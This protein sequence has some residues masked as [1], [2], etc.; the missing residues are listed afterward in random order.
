MWVTL[1]SVLLGLLAFFFYRN[2][3][4]KKAFRKKFEEI[5]GSGGSGQ[6]AVEKKTYSDELGIKPEVAT[7][8]IRQL[9][10]FERDKKFLEKDLTLV[11]LAAIFQTNSKYVSIIIH[12]YRNK[13]SD[14]YISDLK[15]EHLLM[16]L[17][18]ENKY[19]HYSHKALAD[20]VGFNTTQALTKAFKA[21]NGVSLSFFTEALKKEQG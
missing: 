18:N 14:E 6:K 1:I 21:K 2:I 9:E 15:V 4:I 10:K 5:T 11:K 20:E 19:R 12:H 13:R 7:A 8:I 3:R 17:Q 16:L